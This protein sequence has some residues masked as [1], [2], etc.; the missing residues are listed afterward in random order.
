MTVIGD[1][2]KVQICKK[3]N[4]LLLYGNVNWYVVIETI[5][6]ALFINFFSFFFRLDNSSSAW[7][8]NNYIFSHL[9]VMHVFQLN[10]DFNESIWFG[11]C[12]TFEWHFFFLLL[13]TPLIL[14]TKWSFFFSLCLR[15]DFFYYYFE[16][17]ILCRVWTSMLMIMNYESDSSRDK[18][19]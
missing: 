13:I 9:F 6:R 7:S 12:F 8:S 5:F 18:V 15:C 14:S 11:W 16:N 4:F 17:A 1:S 19:S 10:L 2:I 3:T